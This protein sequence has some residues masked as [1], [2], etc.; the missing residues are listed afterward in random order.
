MNKFL[1]FLVVIVSVINVCAQEASQWR[2]SNRDGIY[3]ESDLLKEWPADG[4]KLLWHFDNLGAG[5][6]SASI[7]DGKIFTAG[8][9][10]EEGFVI[11]LSM[12]GTELWRTSYGKEWIENWDGVRSTPTVDGSKVY[13]MSG[14]G[15]LVCLNSESGELLWKKDLFADF[16][17]R[18][19]QWG[20]TE[21]L[22]IYNEH[23][24]CMPGGPDANV[25]SLNKNTGGLIWKSQGAGG[26]SAY[27]SPQLI[28]HNGRSMIVAHAEE[29][30]IGIDANS[31]KLMWSF[32]WT[33]RYAVHPNTPIYK[34]GK[35]FTASGYGQGCVML[36]IST[37]GMEVK[38]LWRNEVLDNQMGGYVVL[39]GK[40]YG[41]GSKSRKWLCLDWETGNEDYSYAELKVG[42]IIAAENLLYWYSQGGE[43]A[44]VEP[45]EKAFKIISQ[46]D[47]PYGEKQH[48]AHLVIYNKWLF[49][50][51]GTSL[52]VYD[53]AK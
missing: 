35:L 20:V 34:D 12:A 13:L 18:N 45:Q 49:V 16:D 23:L 39:N 40:I 24:I 19:I 37:D 47:V 31:G 8:T 21:N 41:A 50:R 53:I 46:F 4:P 38:E 15:I 43:V 30:I 17:G 1:V 48:W 29:N 10:G 5:H 25:I 3:Q 11:A 7:S 9:D 26:K 28:T 27:G 42:N 32:P 22:L 2:G 44:L 33:N 14:Y 36:E 52:M 6:A 51:H